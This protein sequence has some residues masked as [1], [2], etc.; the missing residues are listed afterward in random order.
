M[1]DA[2]DRDDCDQAM[3]VEVLAAA[4]SDAATLEDDAKT[5][6]VLWI[7]EVMKDVVVKVVVKVSP[8]ETCV[9]VTAS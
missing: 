8:F 3:P 4:V 5:V 2:A 1:F 9:S 6:M 7:V